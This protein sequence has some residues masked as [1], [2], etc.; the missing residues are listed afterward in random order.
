MPT[1]YRNTKFGWY[2]RVQ[3][4]VARCS[5]LYDIIACWFVDEAILQKDRMKGWNWLSNFQACLVDLI[6]V[7][8]PCLELVHWVSP[9]EV[10]SNLE[11]HHFLFQKVV[12]RWKLNF[13]EFIIIIGGVCSGFIIFEGVCSGVSTI[14]GI[15]RKWEDSHIRTTLQ[16][17]LHEI[18]GIWFHFVIA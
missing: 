12:W 2:L 14:P 10:G 5:C 16:Q 15:L 4:C 17:I 7:A 6:W 3:L 9:L 11:H 18:Q 13:L 8:L 1:T